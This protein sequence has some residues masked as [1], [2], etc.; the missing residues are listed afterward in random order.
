MLVCSVS[1]LARRAAIVADIAEAA[2]AEDGSTTGNI[3]FAALVDDPASV[4]EIVDAYLGEIMLEA[5]S[6]DAAVDASIPGIYATDITETMIATHTQDGTVGLPA[7]ARSTILMGAVG[8]AVVN[9][10][11]TARAA[12]ASGVMVNS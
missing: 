11:T 7:V 2:S 4:G 10:G 9:T 5:A 3:V 12:N 8:P 1:Q 6:A